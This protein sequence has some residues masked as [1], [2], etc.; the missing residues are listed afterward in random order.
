M[1]K[2]LLLVGTSVLQ[3]QTQSTKKRTF[4]FFS[5][6]LGHDFYWGSNKKNNRKRGLESILYAA[7][8]FSRL[9]C[10]TSG[11]GHQQSMMNPRTV[12]FPSPS[13]CCSAAA[14][15]SRISLFKYWQIENKQKLL[16]ILLCL[17]SSLRLSNQS[18][19]LEDQPAELR[20]Q[21]QKVLPDCLFCSKTWC[22]DIILFICSSAPCGYRPSQVQA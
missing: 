8:G 9:S 14:F 13:F 20:I 7:V 5:N 15:I 11:E 21:V 16:L 17:G 10:C 4:S 12:D 18:N 1:K 2:N 6:E 3:K 19:L 22:A